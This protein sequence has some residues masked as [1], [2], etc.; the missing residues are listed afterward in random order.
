MPL[1][2]VVAAGG[3]ALRHEMV[4]KLIAVAAGA[5]QPEHMPVVDDLGLRFAKDHRAHDGSAIRREAWRAVRLEHRNMAA[6]PA[7]V[8][9]AGRKA[10]APGDPVAALDRDG[11]AGAGHV[12]SPGED[13]ARSAEHL[14]GDFRRQVG[15]DHRAAGILPEAPGRAAVA[16]GQ[17]FEDR[18]VG[19]RIEFGAAQ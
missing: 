9:A 6:E 14:A 2:F 16:A 4:V 11:A 7:G 8:A 1:G 17:L 3:V 18:G 12:R 19:Q 5:A 10:P 15:R 13:A